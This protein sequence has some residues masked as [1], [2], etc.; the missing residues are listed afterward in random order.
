MKA[1]IAK[2]HT[3]EVLEHLKIDFKEEKQ[4]YNCATKGSSNRK[5][6]TEGMQEVCGKASPQTH[7]QQVP[8]RCN[9][10]P[11]QKIKTET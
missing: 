1:G 9:I 5:W 4:Y 10:L 11:V 8:S 2:K 3:P 7:D 6:A